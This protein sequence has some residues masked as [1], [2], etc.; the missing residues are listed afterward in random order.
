MDPRSKRALV[1]NEKN[2]NWLLLDSIYLDEYQVGNMKSFYDYQLSY[3]SFCQTTY[4]FYYAING[5]YMMW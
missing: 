1:K 5:I 2:Y 3:I 4:F